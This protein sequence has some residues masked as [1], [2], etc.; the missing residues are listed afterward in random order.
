MVFF[1]WYSVNDFI[2]DDDDDDDDGED[3]EDDVFFDPGFTPE[4]EEISDDDEEIDDIEIA[5]PGTLVELFN[6]VKT[7]SV[8]IHLPKKNDLAVAK[9]RM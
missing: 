9:T 7:F 4:L 5:T 6:L 3:Q 2:V 1:H 8:T